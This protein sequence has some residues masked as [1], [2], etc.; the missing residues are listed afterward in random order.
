[1][2]DKMAVDPKIVHKMILDIA[3]FFRFMSDNE[4]RRL[5][6]VMPLQQYAP[7]AYQNSSIRDVATVCDIL[8]L[9]AIL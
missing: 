8:D 4:E 1:M 5:Y 7:Y 6:Y 9:V 3:D 2:K